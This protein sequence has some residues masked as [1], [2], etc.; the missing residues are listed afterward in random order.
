MTV[1]FW[2]SDEK[3]QDAAESNF[4]RIGEALNRFRRHDSDLAKRGP[5]I[6]N[7][8]DVR[9]LLA[10]GH[11]VADVAEVWGTIEAHLPDLRMAIG[12]LKPEDETTSP[13][14]RDLGE[15]PDTFSVEPWSSHTGL[16]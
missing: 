16:S 7:I 12:A 14:S 2:C 6:K 9:T 13:D 5:P 4:E 10:R 3:T 15:E 11:D 8:I 1:G